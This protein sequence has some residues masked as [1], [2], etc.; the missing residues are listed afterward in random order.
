[1]TDVLNLPDADARTRELGG[2]GPRFWPLGRI[3]EALL[4]LCAGSPARAQV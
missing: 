2:A 4:E 3:A 1:M